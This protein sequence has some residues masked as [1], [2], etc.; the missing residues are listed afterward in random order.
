ACQTG[1]PRHRLEE[2]P[3]MTENAIDALDRQIITALSRDGRLP[4]REIARGIGVSEGTIRS[5]MA[6]L[7]EEGLIRVTVVGS[8]LVLGFDVVAVVMIRVK[9]GHTR[10]TA[11]IL[12]RLP[13]VRFVGTSFGS[14]DITIQTLHGNTRDLHHFVS[15]VIP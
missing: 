1:C 12:A 11:E 5:R 13:N 15:E 4:Y 14:A 9:P 3:S 10:E 6:R 7:Q 8:P 2:R